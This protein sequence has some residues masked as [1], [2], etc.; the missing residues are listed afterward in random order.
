M[1]LK[2]CWPDPDATCLE[3]GCIHCESGGTWVDVKVLKQWASDASALAQRGVST[4]KSAR[5]AFQYGAQSGWWNMLK[6]K[7]AN[8]RAFYGS[9]S[10]PQY[11]Q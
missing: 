3:G 7:R 10:Q 4:R 9:A 2:I 5:D 1:Q 6:R 11:V 8:G